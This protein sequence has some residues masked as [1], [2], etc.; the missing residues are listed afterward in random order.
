MKRKTY[1]AQLQKVTNQ[2]EIECVFATMETGPDHD[3]DLTVKGAFGVQDGVILEGWNHDRGLPVGKGRVFERGSDAV[4]QGQFFLHTQNGRDHY[5]ALKALGNVEFSYTFDILDAEPAKFGGRPGRILKR[6]DVWGVGPVTRGAGLGTR[7]LQLKALHGARGMSP[8]EYRRHVD[9]LLSEAK[10][11][12][13]E[14]LFAELDEVEARVKSMA[15]TS[16]LD[17]YRQ[18]LEGEGMSPNLAAAWAEAE[19]TATA[20]QLAYQNPLANPDWIRREALAQW[21][22]PTR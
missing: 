3:N 21:Q 6:L 22:R 5:E 11:A 18:Q 20:Q 9:Q 13:T 15:P 17:A 7:L 8:K 12:E 19:V 2:G 4:F 14:R 1:Q 10:A 16:R